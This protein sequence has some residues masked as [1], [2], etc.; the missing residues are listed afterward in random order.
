MLLD[1]AA[2]GADQRGLRIS[3][4]R[5]GAAA[6]AGAIASL[7]GLERVIE[8]AYLLWARALG[9]T[10][11]TAEDSGARD[12]KDE[13]AVERAVALED[14]LPAAGVYLDCHLNTNFGCLWLGGSVWSS[15]RHFRFFFL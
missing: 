4:D 15:L 2:H 14:R 1:V 13:C 7:F 8:E 12:G 9:G 6:Q 3:V 5:L 11:G 10:R